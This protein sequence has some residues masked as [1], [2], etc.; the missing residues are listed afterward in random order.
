M[1][2]QKHHDNNEKMLLLRYA[3]SVIKADL[4]WKLTSVTARLF[5]VYSGDAFLYTIQ[6]LE[7]HN[8][9]IQNCTVWV[10]P[11]TKQL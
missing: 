3:V 1:K 7:L 9:F 5:I 11:H 6:F 10:E 2:N 8:N 4:N